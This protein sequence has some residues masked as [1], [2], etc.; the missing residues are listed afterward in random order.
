MLVEQPV[1][2]ARHGVRIGPDLKTRLQTVEERRQQ[3]RAQI[4]HRHMV[5]AGD[6]GMSFRSK[7]EGLRTARADAVAQD[8]RSFRVR[9]VSAGLGRGGK[10]S[11]AKRNGG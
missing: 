8:A 6:E 10:A 3:Y 4:V 7:Q 9:A 1:E 5:A 11:H 2:E